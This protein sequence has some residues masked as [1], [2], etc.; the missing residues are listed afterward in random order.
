[1]DNSP[2]H[3]LGTSQINCIFRLRT[4]VYRP[5]LVQIPWHAARPS[6]A[7]LGPTHDVHPRAF[8]SVLVKLHAPKFIA[9]L[10]IDLRKLGSR[11]ELLRGAMSRGI[12]WNRWE[13]SEVSLL[14]IPLVH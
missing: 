2:T 8:V 11:L 10:A 13:R 7:R 1:M 4:E 12:D 14:S 6:D 3:G 5:L 9:I